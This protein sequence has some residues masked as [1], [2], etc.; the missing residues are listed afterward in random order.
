MAGLIG[1]PVLLLF[2]AVTVLSLQKCLG[3]AE[4]DISLAAQIVTTF[5]T[6]GIALFGL[7]LAVISFQGRRRRQG[8]A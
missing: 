3:N 2:G 8:W 7:W 4:R 6:G 1:F 5:I